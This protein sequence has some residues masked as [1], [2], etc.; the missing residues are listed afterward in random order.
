MGSGT[1]RSSL[2]RDECKQLVPEDKWDE[3]WDEFYFADGK[4]VS[5]ELAERVWCKA[6][7]WDAHIAAN[8]TAEPKDDDELPRED[9]QPGASDEAADA[10]DALVA[11]YPRLRGGEPLPGVKALDFSAII[12][13]KRRQHLQGTREWVFDAVEKWRIDPDAAKLFWLV[14]G[15]GTGKSVAAAELLV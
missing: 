1:S 13:D 10:A 7:R 15:G 14:G 4:S 11:T 6:E 2:T 9:A 5:S 12:A 8:D 3:S